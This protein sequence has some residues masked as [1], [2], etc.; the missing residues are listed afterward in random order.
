MLLLALALGTGIQDKTSAIRY[1]L[2][3]LNAAPAIYIVLA[4]LCVSGGGCGGGGGGGGGGVCVCVCVCVCWFVV[5]C[6]SSSLRLCFGKA[7]LRVCGF[8]VYL[9]V[10]LV[11]LTTINLWLCLVDPA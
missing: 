6:S 9:H 4:N 11:T 3:L 8:F 7:M 5:D 1:H 10:Y 2:A